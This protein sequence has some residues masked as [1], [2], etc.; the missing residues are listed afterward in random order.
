VL[1]SPRATF[2]DIVTAPR[3]ADALLVTFLTSALFTCTFLRTEVG[4]LALLDQWERTAAAFGRNLND[5]QYAA[6]DRASREDSMAY[7]LATSFA[8]GP[9]L[10]VGL[11]GLLIAAFRAAGAT[12]ATFTQV[13]AVVSHAGVILALRRVVETPVMYAR[14][15]L[16]SPVTLGWFVSPFNE[17]SPIARFAAIVDLF[18]IWWV[19]V[20]AIGTAV[21]YQQSAR[22]LSL[23]FVGVYLMLA[24]ILAVVMAATGGTA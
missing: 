22:R 8:A 14:E 12:A 23:M 10:S 20:L 16:A 9:I 13:M 3:W 5:T 15:T 11:S 21:L 18:V 19:V 1:A 24:V 7:G 2:A 6:L 4:Q 17:S